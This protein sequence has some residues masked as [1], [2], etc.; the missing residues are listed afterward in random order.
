MLSSGNAGDGQ[1]AIPDAIALLSGARRLS[2]VISSALQSTRLRPELWLVL[3]VVAEQPRSLG[4]VAAA[5]A[6]HKGTVSR[7]LAS[8][9][10]QGLVDCKVTQGDQRLKI[11]SL[12]ALGSYRLEIARTRIA[13]ALAQ[14]GIPLE[15]GRR[16][17]VHGVCQGLSLADRPAQGAGRTNVLSTSDRR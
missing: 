11:T 3:E 8:L 10:E 2:S 14:L 9:E 16:A 5:L 12:T 17:A 4:R 13:E 1:L 6:A 15:A 7:W